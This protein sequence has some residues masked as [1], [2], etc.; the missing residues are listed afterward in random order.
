MY[1]TTNPTIS[2]QSITGEIVA[3][4]MAAPFDPQAHR[5]PDEE[6][7][8]EENVVIKMRDFGWSN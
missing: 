4:F 6:N 3:F 1:S 7:S 5:L 8:H 2:A